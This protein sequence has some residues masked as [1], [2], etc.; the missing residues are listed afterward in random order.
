MDSLVRATAKRRERGLIPVHN[1]IK[2]PQSFDLECRQKGEQWLATNPDAKR[3]RDLWSPFRLQLA[4][5]FA[6]RCGYAAMWISSGTIDHH[7]SFHENPALA[8]E[9]SNFRYVEGWINSSKSR[10]TAANFLD[11]FE[12]ESGWFEIELPSLQLMLTDRVPEDLRTKAEYTLA[13]LPIQHDERIIRARRAWLEMYEQG[14]P[15]D[16]IEEKAPL[17]AKAIK[18]H[19]WPQTSR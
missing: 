3:P 11:P 12:V 1:P 17:I 14:T 16:V 6:E 19:N 2:E 15:I 4:E 7:V 8:Y 10:K 18:R 13:K 5:G 9:W